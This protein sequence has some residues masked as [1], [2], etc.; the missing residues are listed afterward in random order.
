M[1]VLI[2]QIAKHLK[3]EF[4]LADDRLVEGKYNIEMDAL[5]HQGMIFIDDNTYTMMISN[6]IILDLPNPR[7]VGVDI[8][9]NW[10]Y[11]ASTTTLGNSSEEEGEP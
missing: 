9:K 4:N 8:L 11:K 10:L 5:V 2:T 6:N 7:K 1:G 3:L